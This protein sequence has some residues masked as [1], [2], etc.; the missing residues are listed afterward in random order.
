M[1]RLLQGRFDD[2][3]TAIGRFA[4]NTVAGVG[5]LADVATDIGLPYE[6]TDFGV[7]MASWGAPAGPYLFLPFMGPSSLRDGTGRLVDSLA[8][9]VRI[10]AMNNDAE[11][12]FYTAGAL[13]ALD[14]RAAFDEV[15]QDARKNSLDSYATLR[16]SYGQNRA[17]AINAQLDRK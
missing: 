14:T 8:D 12:P 16:S 17:A 3:G 7:T 15:I 5:G 9:P 1:N 6:K 2:A 4:V 11:A 13:R 10:I